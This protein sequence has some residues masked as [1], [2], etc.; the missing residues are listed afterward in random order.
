[1]SDLVIVDY[2][3][4]NIASVKQAVWRAGWDADLSRG[5]DDLLTADRILL[6]GVGAAGTAMDRLRGGGYVEALTE[7]VRVRG[8]PMLCICVGMQLLAEELHEF[9]VHQGLGWI[10]GKVTR[11]KEAPGRR[12]PHMGWNKVSRPAGGAVPP[13][14]VLDRDTYYYF[15]HSYE[16][17]GLDPSVLAGEADYAGRVPAAIRTETVFATQFHP[18]KSQVEGEKLIANFMRWKV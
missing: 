9:G 6:P 17:T 5:P 10:K 13:P 14:G 18:E 11:L 1:M 4:G 12:V 15:A 16:M 2:G 8:T 3:A 7:A